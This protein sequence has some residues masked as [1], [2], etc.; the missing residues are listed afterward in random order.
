M[1]KSVSQL[2]ED[3]KKDYDLD[4]SVDEVE[5]SVRS[6]K[7]LNNF[8]NNKRNH[9][10]ESE[11]Y[12]NTLANLLYE[13]LEK[14]LSPIYYRR[15]NDLTDVDVEGFVTRFEEIMAAKRDINAEGA[16][17]KPYGGLGP[18]IYDRMLKHMEG[19]DKPLADIWT[20]SILDGELDPT[21]LKN[22]SNAAFEQLRDKKAP[23]DNNDK[24]NLE[25]AVM[26]LKTM[27]QVY[28]KR[29]FAWR[30]AFWHWRRWY[31]EAK[32]IKQLKGEIETYR[33]KNFPVKEIEDKYAVSSMGNFS[34]LLAAARDKAMNAEAYQKEN[35]EA[36]KNMEANKRVTAIEKMNKVTADPTFKDKL[37]D[38]I[39]KKL[40][41]AQF[42]EDMQRNMLS[43]AYNSNIVGT[44]KTHNMRFDE[45]SSKP[46]QHVIS[47]AKAIF[48][49]ACVM[50][51]TFGYKTPEERL[52]VA[53]IIT[54]S[55]MQKLSPAAFNSD[56]YGDFARGYALRNPEE[57]NNALDANNKVEG[58]KV[59]E[60]FEKA[61]KLYAELSREKVFIKEI[62]NANKGKVSGPVNEAPEIKAPAN[63]NNEFLK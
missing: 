37:I 11:I 61:N 9:D 32:Y 53:Q 39:V 26:S 59:A 47:G 3:F 18:K 52:A 15:S 10:A 16:P 13:H 55:V 46:Q 48:K 43:M 54:D 2:M 38:G 57:F 4:V 5:R 36:E 28:K 50:A 63:K 14:K 49:N 40:P 1:G 25:T 19:L 21:Y 20:K 30:A 24:R 17:Q 27:E 12:E 6:F 58:E 34:R 62:E 22:S 42:S 56:E 7:S 23:L 60:V 31:R 33:S 44:M 45:E 41:A 51:N 35:D 8:M 29:G